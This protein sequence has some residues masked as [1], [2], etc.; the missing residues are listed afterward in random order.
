MSGR[1]TRRCRA[2]WSS[3]YYSTPRGY[4]E[5]TLAVGDDVATQ[6]Q[7]AR[8]RLAA[9]GFPVPA[10]EAMARYGW[11]AG[12]WRAL[13][14]A[15]ACTSRPPSDRID[16]VLDA[17]ALGHAGLRVM[18]LVVFSGGVRGGR[19]AHGMID[20]VVGAVGEAVGDRMPD[21]ALRSLAGRR[22]DRRRGKRARLSAADPDPVFLHRHARRLRLH[23][24][25]GLFDGQADGRAWA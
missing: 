1:P 5:R 3:V 15:R 11:V 16:R 6:L 8:E 17:Q 14:S 24:P 4:L 18:M 19:A 20:A 13:S 7:A 12:C 25:G 21:G 9:A 2:I 23:G 10:V 22:R